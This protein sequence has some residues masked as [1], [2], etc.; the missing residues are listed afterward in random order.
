MNNCALVIGFLL[1]A[2]LASA[3]QTNLLANPGFETGNTAGWSAFG[4]PTLTAEG[5]QVHTGSFACAVTGRTGTFM[6]ISQSLVGLAQSGQIQSGQVYNVS[7]WVMLDGGTNQTMQLTMQ[8]TDGSGTGYTQIASGTVASSGW[9]QLSGTYTYNPSGSVSALNFYAEVPSSSTNSYFIY[10]VHFD[11][12]VISNQPPIDGSSSVD[13]NNVHQRIDGFGASS[14]WNSTWTTAEADLLFSTNNNINYQGATFNGVGLS[15]LRNRIAPATTTSASGTPTTVE[16]SIMQLAQ[17]RGARIWSAPWTPAPGFKD[18]GVVNGGNYLG[19]GANPTNLAYAS[20]L[21]NYVASMKNTYGINLYA[22]SIQNEPDGNHPDPNGYDSCVWTPQKIHDFTTNLFTALSNAGFS[23]TKIML[24]ESQNWTDP[25][26]LAATAMGDPA[27]APAVGIIANHDYVGDNSVGDHSTPAAI[28]SYG[29]A[30]WE[31]EV[32][33]LS[34]SD[35]SIANGV[36]YAQRIHLFMTQA[37]ANAYH[38]WWLVGSG[39]GNEGLLDTSAAVTKRLFTFGQY[40][41][42]V[43]P[44]FYRIDATSSQPSALISA[45]K[46]SS[47]TAF[48]IVA[49]NTS[50]TTPVNQTINLT[51]FTAGSVTPWITSSTLSLAQQ[52]AVNVTNFSFSYTL[53]PMSVVTFVGKA[54][55]SPP[56][57]ASVPDLT[58]NAGATLVTTNSAFDPDAPSQTLTFSLMGAPANAGLSTN[59]GTN[60][61]FTWRPM[62]SQANTTNT[63]TIK[64]TDNGSPPLSASQSF[65]ITVNPLAPP[66]V[67]SI[68]AS[69]GQISLVVDGPTGPDYSL[70]AS[71]NLT[72]WQAISTTNSPTLP[73]TLIDTNYNLYPVRYYRIQLGP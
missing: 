50:A 35:S 51:G 20:Q 54:A 45:Y 27:V 29:R 10:D 47:S 37:Q 53:P 49:V 36:Y 17:A 63:I 11:G 61:V 16:T 23:S 7:A 34:G 70:L 39:Q 1:H 68:A 64:V 72:D 15:L 32:A 31:T 22:L 56:T 67:S 52:T 2:G 21:A 71:T 65:T 41:R 30:L 43:R 4:S 6:G 14:A 59:N 8:K 55:N 9:T 42:F 58:I 46:D 66:T 62:V 44:N 69:A 48:A 33:L 73:I 13:W 25:Q 60:A 19:S 26:G 3:Q 28:P 38:Y 5:A 40:S 18:S 57:L 12:T 24:P